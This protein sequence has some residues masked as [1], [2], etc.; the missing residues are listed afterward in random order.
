[1]GYQRWRAAALG[2][3]E[4]P[5][6]PQWAGV[7]IK[8]IEELSAAAFGTGPKSAEG[9]AFFGSRVH[10]QETARVPR[11]RR[12]GTRLL[13]ER[14]LLCAHGRACSPNE[15]AAA[16]EESAAVEMRDG[17]CGVAAI[18]DLSC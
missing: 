11:Q 4:R 15:L 10:R 2:E 8:Q 12:R 6:V 13:L 16:M 3:R 7:L 5:Y 14:H 1:M 18:S 9:G 17:I